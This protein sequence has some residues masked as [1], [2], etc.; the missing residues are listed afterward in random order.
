METSIEAGLLII[1]PDYISPT[2]LRSVFIGFY[3]ESEEHDHQ[4]VFQLKEL[5]A[6]SLGPQPSTLLFLP[7]ENLSR[8]FTSHDTCIDLNFFVGKATSIPG[9]K[10]T[11]C[12]HGQVTG[13]EELQMTF[14]WKQPQRSCMD[15]R[16]QL[17]SLLPTNLCGF[18]FILLQAV[19]FCPMSLYLPHPDCL[20]TQTLV[21][22][23]SI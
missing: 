1:Y 23:S 19:L 11:F 16:L 10:H 17:H 12:N 13:R 14:T 3:R 21:F 6:S 4:K 20:K 2:K 22:M 7:G 9:L 8:H 15:S 5:S 18:L